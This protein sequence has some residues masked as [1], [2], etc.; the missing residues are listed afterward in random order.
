TRNSGT[1]WSCPP[2]C[3]VPVTATPC[4]T[5]GLMTA[6]TVSDRGLKDRL[7]VLRLPAGRVIRSE[8]G[9]GLK[10]AS[11]TVT[12][13]TVPPPESSINP[14]K[15]NA[16][17]WKIVTGPGRVPSTNREPSRTVVGPVNVLSPV[18]RVPGT[19]VNVRLPVPVTGPEMVFKLSD[20]TVSA[21]PF[22]FTE[23]E[24]KKDSE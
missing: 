13:P 19:L 2:T 24:S 4:A 6:N 16:G 8:P 11:I 1:R 9:P 21:W 20:L 7:P 12:S 17:V 10:P 14:P 23:P 15:G 5:P 3:T 22:K 18:R